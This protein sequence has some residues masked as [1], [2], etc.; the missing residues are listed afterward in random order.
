MCVVSMITDHYQH[1]WPAPFVPTPFWPKPTF[2]ESFP[3]MPVSVPEEPKVEITKTEYEEYLALKKKAQEY[4]EKNKEPN[5]AKP[6]I[7]DWEQKIEAVLIKRGII[8]EEDAAG[9]H[10]SLIKEVAT[11]KITKTKGKKPRL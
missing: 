4:D 7:E 8:T 2:P 3:I 9:Y 1:K 10:Y 11:P 5:C 6:E